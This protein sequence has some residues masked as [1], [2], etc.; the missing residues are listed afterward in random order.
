MSRRTDRIGEQIRAE[1]A[2]LLREEISDPRVGLLSVTRV[3][4]APDL[5]NARIHWSSF[6]GP[7]QPDP[8]DTAAGLASAASFLRRRLARTLTTKRVPELRFEHDPSLSAGT[9]T[10]ALIS[11]LVHESKE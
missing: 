6:E 7:D 11:E 9:E 10:L 1:L 3:D 4:V 5:S 8:A 2:R